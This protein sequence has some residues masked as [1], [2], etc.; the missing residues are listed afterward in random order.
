MVG[1][2]LIDDADQKW[3][4]VPQGNGLFV[5]NHGASIDNAGDDRWKWFQTGRGSGNLPSNA[6]NCMVKD[7]DGFIWLGTDKGIAIIQCPGDV[8]TANGCEAF[9]PIVQQDNFAGFLFENE[10]VRAIAVDAANRKWVGT[11]NGVW[12]ISAVGEKVL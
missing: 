2:V 6:V 7:K 11:R 12:L 4:Q 9:Q 5:Y 10:D 3:I 1:A 8:F